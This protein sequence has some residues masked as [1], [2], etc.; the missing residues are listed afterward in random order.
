MKK[1][2]GV[3]FIIAL[4]ATFFL[5][6][7]PDSS[8]L[9]EKESVQKVKSSCEEML[10]STNDLENT[11]N[12]PTN[13]DYSFLPESENFKTRT[14]ESV[15]EGANFAG[16]FNVVTWGCGTDCFG[17]SI[18]D[19]NNGKVIEYSPVHEGYHLGHFSVDTKYLIH[20]PVFAGEDRNYY[21]LTKNGETT[22]LTLI[23]T[24]KS[25]Q[26]MYGTPQ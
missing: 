23:C 18:V 4:I 25:E 8:P 14:E 11:K 1:I 6:K 24:E 10:T 17:Y 15:K 16:H 5:I 13:I 19:M 26:D 21:E 7:R 3:A 22:A 9:T 2:I 12:I 20:N